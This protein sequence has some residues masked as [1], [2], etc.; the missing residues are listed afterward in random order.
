MFEENIQV[1]ALSNGIRVVTESIN[2]VQSVSIGIWVRAGSRDE[3][4]QVR[5]I[6][7]FIEHMLFK[8]TERRD[9]RQIAD[10]IESRGGALNAFTD[11]EY[12]CYYAKALSEHADVVMDV[13]TDMLLHSQL[14]PDE[15]HRERNVV[16]EEIKRYKD[17]PDDLVHDLFASVIWDKHPLGRSVI[18]VEKTVASLEREELTNYLS[19]HY[20]PGRIVVSAAG[21]VSHEEMVKLAQQYLGEMTGSA[22][23]PLLKPP[24][25]SGKN[26]LQKKKTEQVHFCLGCQAFSQ[27]NDDRY[28]LTILDSVLGGN[29]SSRLFQ[30]IREKRG[31]AYSIGSY[32]LSFRE[33]GLFTIYGGTSP[34]SFDEVVELTHVEIQKVLHEGLLDDEISKAKNQIKGALVLGLESMSSRMMR[35]GKSMLYFDRVIPLQEIVS[36]IQA[37]QGSDIIQIA[38]SLFKDDSL[39]L[40][41]IGPF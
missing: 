39:S 32:S 20:L 26:K 18:G 24:V 22:P 13:L 28:R 35:M 11:K 30:E 31:L 40:A 25:S 6:S 14:S 36:K 10:E 17:T 34:A 33:S 29:M 9:A 37:V 3:S 15:L 21:N 4:L 1:S 27:H 2:H 8:G 16:L 19:A 38:E 5:G 7:H 41:A 12:T 23:D